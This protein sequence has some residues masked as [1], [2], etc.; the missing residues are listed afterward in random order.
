MNDEEKNFW[1]RLTRKISNNKRRSSYPALKLCQLAVDDNYV[2]NGFG[3]QIIT[4]VVFL[5][6]EFKVG[7][8][9]VTVDALPEAE[10]FYQ[11]MGFV[12]LSDKPNPKNGT[13]PMYFDLG[14]ISTD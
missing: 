9:F 2:A 11:K 3:K 14:R 1:N 5:A 7:C 8:R 10:S 6:L 4:Q 13:I 12:R